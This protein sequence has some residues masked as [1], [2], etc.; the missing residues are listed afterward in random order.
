MKKLVILLN[1]SILVLLGCADSDNVSKYKSILFGELGIVGPITFSRYRVTTNGGNIP[2]GEVTD[3]LIYLKN[4]GSKTAKDVYAVLNTNSPY[5]TIYTF[6]NVIKAYFGN[7]SANSESDYGKA[8]NENG[9]VYADYVSYRF[10]IKSSAPIG[11]IINF[12]LSITDA[13]GNNWTSNFS[14]TVQ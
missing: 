13:D 6:D 5:V 1:I 7:I 3:I 8:V 14:I 2:R 10:W 11:N 12:D 9:V 4:N